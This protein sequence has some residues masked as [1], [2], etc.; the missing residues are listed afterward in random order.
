MPTYKNISDQTQC[1]DG[2]FIRP[3]EII[4]TEQIITDPDFQKISDDPIWS[5]LKFSQT[6]N[7]TAGATQEISVPT[8]N[9][10][11]YVAILKNTCGVTIYNGA[12]TTIVSLLPN[13]LVSF[14]THGKVET[15]TIEAQND[16]EVSIAISETPI[17]II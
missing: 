12:S 14:E 6:Y 4:E 8:P 16:G 3:N 7:L 2:K 5:P 10:N 11:M 13:Q 15:L 1:V 17:E 9:Q